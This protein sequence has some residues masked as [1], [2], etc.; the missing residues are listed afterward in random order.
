MNAKH[1]KE[2]WRYN[3]NFNWKTH[4]FSISARKRGVHSAVIAN[5]P[6]RATIPPGEQMANARLISAA[7]KLLEALEA[8]LD[9]CYDVQ[10]DDDTIKA[11]DMAKA[12]IRKAR[13]GK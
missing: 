8:L 13:E 11:V 9:V 5:I 12:A 4:P 10:R 6:V 1:T 2:E 7:P 3:E